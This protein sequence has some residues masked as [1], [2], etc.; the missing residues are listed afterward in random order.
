MKVCQRL[1]PQLCKLNYLDRNEVAF[2]SCPLQ[3]YYDECAVDSECM[4]LSSSHRQFV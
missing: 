3:G 4:R 2:Q 1:T